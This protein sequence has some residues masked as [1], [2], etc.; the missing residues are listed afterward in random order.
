MQ[1]VVVTN[2]R[3]RETIRD[4]RE[5]S[6]GRWGEGVG[7]CDVSPLKM[8]ENCLLKIFNILK[9]SIQN[10]QNPAFCKCIYNLSIY[11]CSL[12]GPGFA[13][14]VLLYFYTQHSIDVR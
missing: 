6:Y 11:V 4:P 3:I 2:Q 9:S 10:I 12:A 5:T 8:V 13:P 1:Q 14:S 7:A